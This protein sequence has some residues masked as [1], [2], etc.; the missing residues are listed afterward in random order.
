MDHIDPSKK[1]IYLRV[2]LRFLNSEN[3]NFCEKNSL[4]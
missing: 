3:W 1:F 4:E 2:F